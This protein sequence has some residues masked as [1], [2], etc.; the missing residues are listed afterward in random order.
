ML[1]WFKH[2]FYHYEKRSQNKIVTF[3]IPRVYS[4]EK[5][6][7][8]ESLKL[9]GYSLYEDLE[10]GSNLVADI[11]LKKEKVAII[12]IEDTSSPLVRTQLVKQRAAI[13]ELGL[14]CFIFERTHFYKSLARLHFRL[15]QQLIYEGSPP[16][17]Q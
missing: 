13:H 5:R 15:R 2:V 9:K 6:Y 11:F 3:P 17:G 1:T 10:L 4:A 16:Y 7:V 14:Q 8:I 12:F